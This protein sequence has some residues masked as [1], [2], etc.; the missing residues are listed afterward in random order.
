MDRLRL[1]L[2]GHRKS[3]QFC[4]T[5]QEIDLFAERKQ[6]KEK[7]QPLEVWIKKELDAFWFKAIADLRD[8]F[9]DAHK[10]FWEKLV[11][12]LQKDLSDISKKVSDIRNLL[13]N[14]RH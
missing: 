6:K 14:R 1:E 8:E 13:Q 4:K 11:P 5:C 10:Q 7:E 3:Y 12:L 9:V 2:C